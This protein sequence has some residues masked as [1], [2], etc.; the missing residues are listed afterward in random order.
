[1]QDCVIGFSDQ[2]PW[3]GLV[4][5]S[6][7][8][9]AVWEYSKKVQQARGEKM[10]QKRGHDNDEAAKFR[11]T[12]E[13]R[14]VI[15]NYFSP[16]K[17][18]I[19]V[20]GPSLVVVGGTH[21]RLSNISEDGKWVED[22]VFIVGNERVHRRKGQSAGGVMKAWR[23]LRSKA[24][25]LFE[26]ITLMQQPAATCDSVIM[27]WALEELG[28]LYPCSIWMR[29]LSGGGGFSLN[30]KQRMQ[31]INQIPT[32]VLGKMT[33]CLQITDTDFAFRLKALAKSSMENLRLE[34]RAVAAKAGVKPK[35]KCGAYEI[36]RL[37][38]ESADKLREIST[39]E[40]LVLAAARRNGF[41]AYR[42]DFVKKALVRPDEAD[43]CKS[44]PACADSHR[45]KAAWSE[46]RYKWF[47]ADGR[48]VEPN[49]KECSLA[50][51]LESHCDNAALAGPGEITVKD[52]D[53]KGPTV[54][55]GGCQYEEVQIALGEFEGFD[56][57]DLEADTSSA[58]YLQLS[59]KE[60]M[61]DMQTSALISPQAVV[62]ER[63]KV[64]A[65]VRD[66]VLKAR[67]QAA[68][69]RAWRKKSRKQ[70]AEDGFPRAE[71]FQA[72]EDEAC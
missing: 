59:A 37:I 48:P 1:M 6:K 12:V 39:K 54:R 69:M 18:P 45:L 9:Y 56:D 11:I 4:S 57:K 31:I 72:G 7:Q 49:M 21:A 24:P 20:M 47:D 23:D 67:G 30:A 14:Q 68:F 34:L 38:K 66:K 44:L 63:S 42:P 51:T 64:E 40:N 50:K 15:L 41:L 58:S 35:L 53:V 29:D 26:G 43:W 36:L 17:D 27:S 19:G 16:D 3:W 46:D 13:L 52:G 2:V 5:Q 71:L 25:E 70:I 55:V 22:E 28:L 61:L 33:A 10:S 32:W 8:L 62:E 60:R 65:R